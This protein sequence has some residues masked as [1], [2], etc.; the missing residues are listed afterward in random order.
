MYAFPT[1]SVYVY[2]QNVNT[3]IPR[4][5]KAFSCSIMNKPPLKDSRSPILYLPACK[6]SMSSFRVLVVSGL[7][8]SQTSQTL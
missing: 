6:A 5:S 1:V 7:V 4:I 3:P 2:T 8:Q